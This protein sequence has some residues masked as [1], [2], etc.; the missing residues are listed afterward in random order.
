MEA[1]KK[2]TG[3][4]EPTIRTWL[5]GKVTP[6]ML[7]QKALAEYFQ[8]TPEELFPPKDEGGLIWKR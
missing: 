5:T 4:S 7:C 1:M 8:C 2:V 6:D 3:K